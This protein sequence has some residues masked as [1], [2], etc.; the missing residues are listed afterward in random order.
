M[1]CV[2]ERA[3]LIAADKIVEIDSHNVC[4]SE[5]AGLAVPCK[6]VKV[7]SHSVL[8][9]RGLDWYMCHTKLLKL[10]MTFCDW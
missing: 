5:R 3:G 8:C 9:L 7:D 10:T 2:S 1:F 4:V 6:I